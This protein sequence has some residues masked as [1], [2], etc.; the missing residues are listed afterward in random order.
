MI[1]SLSKLY[2]VTA[3]LCAFIQNLKMK[4]K[5]KNILLSPFVNAVELKTAETFGLNK[6]KNVF[7][8]KN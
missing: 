8:A 5:R 4:I 6:N 2:R 3:W 7:I 1:S